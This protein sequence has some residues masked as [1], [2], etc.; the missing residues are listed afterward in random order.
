MAFDGLF[1][2]HL[3]DLTKKDIINS[4]INSIGQIDNN[5]FV[6]SLWNN[7]S[8]NLIVSLE[9]GNCYINID[10]SKINVNKEYS[11]FL[12]ILK[13]HLCKGEIM[14]FNI[15]NNDRIIEIKII[16]SQV[17]ESKQ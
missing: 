2:R 6:F 5:Y 9:P 17:E 8:M 13:T 11:H 16:P 12:N 4:R 14:D 7:S 15:V 1:L 3:V 10:N